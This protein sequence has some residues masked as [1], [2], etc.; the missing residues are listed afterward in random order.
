MIIKDREWK[1]LND[2]FLQIKGQVDLLKAKHRTEIQ[3]LNLQ[4]E[5]LKESKKPDEI[6]ID[7]YGQRWLNGNWVKYE[8]VQF[9]KST[10]NLSDGV[11]WQILKIFRKVLNQLNANFYTATKTQEAKY[12]KIIEKYKLD[13]NKVLKMPYFV[14]RK[15]VLKELFNENT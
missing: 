2:N 15:R 13:K 3:E 9:S 1:E 12:L 5:E 7:I 8:Q 6:V 11:K 4:I 10:V 14:T